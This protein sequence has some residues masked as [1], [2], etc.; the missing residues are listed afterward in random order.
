MRRC[1]LK[2]SFLLIAVCAT[3]AQTLGGDITIVPISSECG[4]AIDAMSQRSKIEEH[5]EGSGRVYVGRVGEIP[6]T[7]EAAGTE[8]IHIQNIQ[9]LLDEGRRGESHPNINRV[10]QGFDGTGR[11]DL[12]ICVLGKG[13]DL[14]RY[15]TGALYT[16]PD[17][18]PMVR[19]ID[20]HRAEKMDDIE[21]FREIVE[22]E[23]YNGEKRLDPEASLIFV[24]P[25]KEP[26]L[27]DPSGQFVSPT[28]D[29]LHEGTH[30]VD[31]KLLYAYLDAELKLR[32][33]GVESP[34]GLFDIYSRPVAGPGLKP[35]MAQNTL[36]GLLQL[37]T[38]GYFDFA[39]QR[40]LFGQ[41]T[42][43]HE[44][45]K[46]WTESNAYDVSAHV[47]NRTY[48]GLNAEAV[49]NLFEDLGYGAV[50]VDEGGLVFKRFGITPSPV[51]KMINPEL[52][53]GDAPFFDL[54]PALTDIMQ[55]T[56]NRAN[57]LPD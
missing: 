38:D 30:Y 41:H 2:L 15:N 52:G 42:F 1:Q 57:S 28:A 6:E 46:A 18:H 47:I 37:P 22:G 19:M 40:K 17:N 50:K 29:L 39:V 10:A 32:R 21:F 27:D 11:N 36:R 54:G 44:L 56:I 23:R 43:S 26:N 4:A 53:D 45:D 31:R 9:A 25:H 20:L 12:F 48:R 8:P 33:L 3:P 5:I 7:F 14:G 34:T 24:N 55:E 13:C 49:R 16:A 51:L 35:W